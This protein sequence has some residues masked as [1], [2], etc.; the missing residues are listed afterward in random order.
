VGDRTIAGSVNA[1]DGSLI[2][3]LGQVIGGN[4]SVDLTSIKLTDNALTDEERKHLEKHLKSISR[5]DYGENM[6]QY[7][8]DRVFPQEDADLIKGLF[9][10]GNQAFGVDATA[11]FNQDQGALSAKGSTQV[12][13]SNP[14][15]LRQIDI[16]FQDDP[17][18]NKKIEALE[19]EFDLNATVE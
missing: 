6:V 10:I 9:T 19:L 2:S 8:I 4:I 1:C 5:S 12:E 13:K 18:E 7:K 3:E 16:S 17:N 15:L 11:K 14:D